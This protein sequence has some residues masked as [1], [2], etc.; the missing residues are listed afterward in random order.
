MPQETYDIIII[1]SGPGG[2]VGAIRASQL[3]LKTCVI[4]KD[5]PGGVCLNMG[6]IP[7]KALLHQAEVFHSIKD[8]ESMGVSVDTSGFDYKQVY[9][10]SRKAATTLSKGVQ[11]LLK[12][13]KIDYIEGEGII[14]GPKE[15]TV[16][17]EK[18]LQGK[19][20]IIATGSRPKTIPGF[21]FDGDRILSSDDALLL[22]KLPKR[23][24][25]LGGGAIGCEFAYIMNSFGVEVT[26]AEMMDHLLPLEERETVAVLERSFKKS[27]IT[28]HTGTKATGVEKSSTGVSAS[29]ENAKG[30]KISIEADQ[31]LVV[32]GR[33]PNSQGIGLENVGI[34][35]ER[36]FVVTG[37]YYQTN[38]PGIFAIGDVINTPWLAHAASKECE[39]VVEYIA[40]EKPYPRIDHNTIPSAVYTEPQVASFGITEDTAKEKNIDYKT[41]SFPYRGAGKAVAMEKPDGMIKII[42]S[43]ETKEAL[44]AHIVG[45]DATELIHEL[46]LGKTAELL[47]EDISTM[48]HAHPTISEAVMESMRAVDGWAIHA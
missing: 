18:K 17:G 4:E 8:L 10:K 15:V 34:Q 42:Y 36:D 22:E 28:I 7:S 29:L 19:N 35:T 39:I 46:L 40:G 45:A 43:P 44:G 48:I 9:K 3:G 6:C 11:F 21:D 38:V 12:K 14:T 2:Y 13:N 41:A 5:K 16:N 23:M 27:G 37:D 47:P 33:T 24:L 1:G 26:I 30:E 32:F 20:I 25:I 31:V